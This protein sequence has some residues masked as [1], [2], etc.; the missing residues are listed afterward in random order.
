LR[1]DAHLELLTDSKLI[2]EKRREIVSPLIIESHAVCIASAS[3]EEIDELNILQASLLAMHRAVT[4]LADQLG[5]STGHVLVDGNQKIPRLQ[6]F[7]QTT[8]V[9]GDLRVAP[10]SAASIVAKVARDHLM[11]ELGKEFPRY[12]F[13]KHKGYG[14]ETHRQAIAQWGPTAHHRKTFSGVR[15]H[16]ESR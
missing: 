11:K 7:C 1:S 10:I 2:S 4:G 3:I 15:E 8:F 16:L 9:K 12:E 14:S 13:E 6:G 5:V